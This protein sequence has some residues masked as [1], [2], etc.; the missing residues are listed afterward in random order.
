MFFCLLRVFSFLETVWSKGKDWFLE[1]QS[2]TIWILA[3]VLINLVVLGKLLNCSGLQLLPIH[4][5]TSCSWYLGISYVLPELCKLNNTSTEWVLRCMLKAR[6]KKTTN[7]QV[8]DWSG[9]EVFL[10]RRGCGSYPALDAQHL[11]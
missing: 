8:I 11:A 7:L 9:R 3:S 6:F 4:R 10:N 5:I 2:P 1:S